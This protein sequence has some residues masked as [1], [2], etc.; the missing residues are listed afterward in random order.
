MGL[1]KEVC[2]GGVRRGRVIWDGSDCMSERIAIRLLLVEDD[3]EDV[4]IFSR[5]VRRMRTYD[6]D[7]VRVSGVE[8]VNG[9]LGDKGFDII[10]SDLNLGAGLNGLDLLQELQTMGD[11]TPCIIVTGAGDETKAVDAM[12]KGAFDY[13]LKDRLSPDLIERTIRSSLERYALKEERDAMMRKLAEMSTTDALTGL[14]NR[15]KLMER[16]KHEI[17][18]ATRSGRPLALLMLDLDHFKDVN[19]RLG[20]QKGDEVLRR[21]AEVAQRNVRKIDLV[22]RYGGEEFAIVLPESGLAAARTAAERIRSRMEALGEGM[23]TVSIGLV[24]WQPG[25]TSDDLLARADKA[26]YG[27]KA[28]GR[29]CLATYPESAMV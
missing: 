18:R 3:D 15:R 11:R 22:A 4:M 21:C 12:K 23:P 20:H 24:L 14:A 7:L 5:Y 17:A 28:R 6:V 16:L 2:F 1:V 9:A 19:D 13:I 8:E 10:V 29:N 27:A 26:L 25:W